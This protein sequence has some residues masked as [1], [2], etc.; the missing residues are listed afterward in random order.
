[1]DISP[2]QIIQK[3]ELCKNI[4]SPDRENP[5]IEVWP[6]VGGKINYR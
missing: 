1:M 3:T 4:M 6:P 2:I 5:I